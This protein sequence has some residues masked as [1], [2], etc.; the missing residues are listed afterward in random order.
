MSV[1]SDRFTSE[2]RT[3]A[4]PVWNFSRLNRSPHL[5]RNDNPPLPT[6]SRG[7]LK[8]MACRS[9]AV[10]S[11]PSYKMLLFL[12]S[13]LSHSLPSTS[14]EETPFRLDTTSRFRAVLKSRHASPT[15]RQMIEYFFSYACEVVYWNFTP[16]NWYASTS[17]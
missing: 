4:A 10:L 15:L 5:L 9:I 1:R 11:I 13:Q 6:A 2:G 8:L 16:N 17:H 14:N 7:H 12:R 3:R